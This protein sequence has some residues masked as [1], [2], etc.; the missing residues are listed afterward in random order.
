M[1]AANSS[2]GTPTLTLL[3]VGVGRMGL[4]YLAAARRL[5]VRVHAA[6]IAHRA[7]PIAGQLDGLTLCR[8]ESDELWAEAAAAAARDSRPDGVLAFS[9]P[10][11][12]AAA[13]VQ[14]ELGL[15]GPSLRAAVISRNKGL[16]RARFAAAGIGQPDYL[17]TDQLA[18]ARG[19][20]EQRLPVVVKPLSSA[21][22]VGVEHVADLEAFDELVTRRAAEGR[23][24]VEQ[25]AVGPEYSWE[26]LVRGGE[27][28]FANLTAKETTGPPN[29]VE[30][31]HHTA[32]PVADGV[33]ADICVLGKAVL[34]ALGMRTGLVHLEFRLSPAGLTVMEVAVRTPGDYL[35]ELL[36]LSYGLDWFELAVRAALD[37]PLPEPPDGPVRFAASYLPIATE[38]VVTAVSGLAEVLGLP[39]VVDGALSVAPGDVVAATRSSMQRVGHVLL[40]AEDRQQLALS[41]AEVRRRLV[42]ATRPELGR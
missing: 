19:W 30:V 22:S 10:Q 17:V 25:A 7:E 32:A 9:E 31:A 39:Q 4:P 6:E 27:V 20:A 26:A 38:G 1:T 14:D 2:A 13:L 29:F 34:A 37:L 16:Q 41:L 8:G 21:G 35:M 33:A 24:L 36:G 11:V 40:A 28:W 3:M 5:G 18:Q 12:L 42:I 15:P 23:L